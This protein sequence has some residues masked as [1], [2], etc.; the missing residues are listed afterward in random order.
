ML[1]SRYKVQVNY[2]VEGEY[3]F[4]IYHEGA[5]RYRGE[6]YSLPNNVPELIQVV[7]R[8]RSRTTGA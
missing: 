3:Y 7:Y 4:D 5:A 2:T 6:L 8:S 1:H